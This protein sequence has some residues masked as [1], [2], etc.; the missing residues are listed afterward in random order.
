[1]TAQA[2]TDPETLKNDAPR[3]VDS[4][5]ALVQTVTKAITTV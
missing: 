4:V 1:M 3:D 2:L 5:Q